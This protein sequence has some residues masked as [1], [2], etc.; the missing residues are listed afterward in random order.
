MGQWLMGHG[1]NGLTNM[2]G[3]RG[4]RV[5]TRDTLTHFTLYL[6]GIPRDFLVHWKLQQRQSKVE[7]RNCYF[8]CLLVPFQN[9]CNSVASRDEQTTS[10]THRFPWKG[11]NSVEIFGK[12]D[13]L[14]WTKFIVHLVGT[15]WNRNRIDTS[16][17]LP[18][19]RKRH[20]VTVTGE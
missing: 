10:E 11:P 4:S 9:L 17:P 13:W 18:R 7:S 1:S 5:S 16:F 19:V 2:S 20:T 6:S 14:M 15:V 12:K 8:D 3:L